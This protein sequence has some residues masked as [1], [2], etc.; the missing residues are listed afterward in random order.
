MALPKH[1]GQLEQEHAELFAALTFGERLDGFNQRKACPDE[2][3]QLLAE[4][5]YPKGHGKTTQQQCRKR[6]G[7][8]HRQHCIA[9]SLGSFGDAGFV[10]TLI[11]E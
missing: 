7:F 4:Q 10:E 2:D 5:L 11:V 1:R 6:A 9:M 8:P 3:N